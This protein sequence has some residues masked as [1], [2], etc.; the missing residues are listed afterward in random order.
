[1]RLLRALLLLAAIALPA[2][3]SALQCITLTWTAPGDDGYSGKAAAYDIRYS[4]TPITKNTWNQAT[5]VTSKPAPGAPGSKHT[6]VL[7]GF[8]SGY[9]YY[10]AIKTVDEAGNWSALSNVTAATPRETC[11]VDKVGNVNCDLRDEVDISDVSALVGYLF[12]GRSLCCPQEANV[13][14]DAD[15]DVDI[16]DLSALINYLFVTQQPLTVVCQ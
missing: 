12:E 13:D 7:C 8:E 3:A 4:T 15:G 5:T 14:G 2:S 10:F 16:S 6:W 1:M 9:T 11:C